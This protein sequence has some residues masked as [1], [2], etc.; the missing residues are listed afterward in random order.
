MNENKFA[1]YE[2]IILIKCTLILENNFMWYRKFFTILQKLLL[3]V[4][5]SSNVECLLNVYSMFV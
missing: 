2:F 4:Q 5:E 3:A 1:K